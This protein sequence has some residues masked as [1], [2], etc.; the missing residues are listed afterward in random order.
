MGSI[1]LSSLIILLF[2]WNLILKLYDI[3]ST[4]VSLALPHVREANPLARAMFDNIG[5][6]PSMFIIFIIYL[7]CLCATVKY[8]KSPEKWLVVFS[9]IMTIVCVNNTMVYARAVCGL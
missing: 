6:V 7:L 5:L 2:V 4:Y 3:F 9:I 1:K 8:S